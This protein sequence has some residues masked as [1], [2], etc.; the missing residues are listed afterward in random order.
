MP[1]GGY[2][3]PSNPAPVSGPGRLSRRTDGKQPARKLANPDY[4]EQGEF[5]AIQQAAPMSEA[6]RPN[7]TPLDAPTQHPDVPVTDGAELG[8]GGGPESLVNAAVY[9][10]E[11]VRTYSY[12]PVLKNLASRPNAT[13]A[14][15][16]LVRELMGG[17]R[18]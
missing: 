14:F 10:E 17:L 16:Q 8:P 6:A 15:R 7:L 11:L 12:L 3:E 9:E 1:R 5:Q 18:P 13:T 4:G 2:Q